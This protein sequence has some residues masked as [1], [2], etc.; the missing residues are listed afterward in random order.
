MEGRFSI[1]GNSGLTCRIPSLS[2]YNQEN[3]VRLFFSNLFKGIR[4]NSMRALRAKISK[5]DE[6]H[7]KMRPTFISGCFSLQGIY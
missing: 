5:R 6:K 3:E 7:T 4:A 1:S 2:K